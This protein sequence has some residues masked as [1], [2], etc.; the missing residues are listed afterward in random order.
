MLN[1]K[2]SKTGRPEQFLLWVIII[3]KKV[4]LSC[5]FDPVNFT[6]S[7][8]VWKIR[9][10]R[11]FFF[12]FGSIPAYVFNL[13]LFQVLC[14]CLLLPRQLE[15]LKQSMKK[16][17]MHENFGK[18]QKEK[19]NIGYCAVYCVLMTYIFVL[20]VWTVESLNNR[21]HTSWRGVLDLPHTC[22]PPWWSSMH[23]SNQSR[24]SQ[25]AGPSLLD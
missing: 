3:T 23:D 4:S 19:K 25:F 21:F 2:Y 6:L 15:Q 24:Q 20:N 22:K 12:F 8:H 10:G 16:H 18:W 11:F 14:N 7:C 13:I 9:G 5:L 1:N 17:K